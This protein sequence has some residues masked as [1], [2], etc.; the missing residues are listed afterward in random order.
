M[1]VTF[2][3]H[4]PGI[5]KTY[6]PRIFTRFFRV[7]DNSL[8]EH[9]SGLGL[10]ICKQIIELHSGTIV[11]DSDENGTIFTITLP[12]NRESKQDSREV[13]L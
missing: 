2:S 9:G 1:I 5:P 13:T 11:V 4:G 6:L 3:D 10:S 7:P 12:L 8:N